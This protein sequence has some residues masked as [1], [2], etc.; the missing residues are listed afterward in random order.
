MPHLEPPLSNS[1][2][3]LKLKLKIEELQ[4]LLDNSLQEQEELREKHDSQVANLVAIQQSLK[5]QL[6]EN[7]QQVKQSLLDSIDQ[8]KI[9]SEYNLC[10]Q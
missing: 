9:K 6:K 10:K 3:T 2:E 1:G 4:L 8:M 7:K 5:A